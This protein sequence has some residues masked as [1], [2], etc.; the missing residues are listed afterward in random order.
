MPGVTQVAGPDPTSRI[1]SEKSARK[2]LFRWGDMGRK[3]VVW[4]KADLP[5]RKARA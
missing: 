4:M 2:Q 3:C 5:H 1:G